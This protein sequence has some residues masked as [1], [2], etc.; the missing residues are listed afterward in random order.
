[1]APGLFGA[2]LF[3]F[4]LQK[5][6]YMKKLWWALCALLMAVSVQAWAEPTAYGKNLVRTQDLSADTLARFIRVNAAKAVNAKPNVEDER[7]WI[8][9]P[10]AVA[11]GNPY[12]LVVRVSGTAL[13]DGEV[14]ASWSGGWLLEG[15][16][17]LFPMIGAPKSG[18]MPGE[19]VTLVAV[20]MPVSFKEDR[21]MS[22]ALGFIGANNIRMD[23]VQ[24]EVWSGAGETNF[25]EVLWTWSPL[26]IGLLAFGLAY[27]MRRG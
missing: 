12:T 7:D 21:T 17:R 1:V 4:F 10:V 6:Q 5:Q 19:R 24:F 15:T 22:P 3:L 27:W 20:S 8:A 11:S 25:V 16:T 23:A 18:V 26:L 14:S 13:G 2:A 9:D